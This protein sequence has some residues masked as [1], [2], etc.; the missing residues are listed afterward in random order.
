MTLGVALVSGLVSVLGRMSVG[1]PALPLPLG[2]SGDWEKVSRPKAQAATTNLGMF[3][4]PLL[5]APRYT[6]GA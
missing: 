1:A 2:L 4:L 5:L 3:L 6:G